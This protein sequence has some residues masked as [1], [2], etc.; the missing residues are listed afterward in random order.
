MKRFKRTGLWAVISA[1]WVVIAAIGF[2][3]QW[4]LAFGPDWLS[5]EV[6]PAVPIASML[7]IAPMVMLCVACIARLWEDK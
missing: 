1:C 4:V 7:C 6:G 3:G 2:A 5:V